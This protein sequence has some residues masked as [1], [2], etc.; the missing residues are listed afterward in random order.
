MSYFRGVCGMTKWNEER[1]GAYERFG[2][3]E[4]VKGINYGVLEWVKHNT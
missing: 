4:N 2:M 1:N 3:A